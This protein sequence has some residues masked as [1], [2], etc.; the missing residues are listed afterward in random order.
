MSSLTTDRIR[1]TATKT[2]VAGG[3]H[4]AGAATH[5]PGLRLDHHAK[6]A[7]VVVALD[8]QDMESLEPHEQVAPRAVGGVGMAARS[9]A[10]RR[11]GHPSRPSGG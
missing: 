8:A 9:N 1:Q 4:P 10:R 11:L 3:D 7:D 5:R 2:A 6:D